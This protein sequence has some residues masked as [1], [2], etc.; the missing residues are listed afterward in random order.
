MAWE[1]VQAALAASSCLS[2]VTPWASLAPGEAQAFSNPAISYCRPALLASQEV[3]QDSM[4]VRFATE[5]PH[6]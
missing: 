6:G 3:T 1:A 2:S 4:P 5:A